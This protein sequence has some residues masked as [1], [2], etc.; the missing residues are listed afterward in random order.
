MDVKACFTFLTN[1]INVENVIC[2]VE[3]KNMCFF[4]EPA[5]VLLLS[6]VVS[7]TC[8]AGMLFCGLALGGGALISD[9]YLNNS[10]IHY[11]CVAF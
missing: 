9:F 11:F 8:T 1:F 7:L 4:M 10:I 3:Y 6:I 2:F 5:V